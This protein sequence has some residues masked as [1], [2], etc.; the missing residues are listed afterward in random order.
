MP[1][2]TQSASGENPPEGKTLVRG[3]DGALYIVSKHNPPE[4][5][6]EEETEQVANLVDEAEEDLSR[7]INQLLPRI[8][9]NCVRNARVVI[10]EVFTED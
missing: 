2:P 10:P 7:K 5:L 9:P 6:T 4:R 3:A 8:M 1:R